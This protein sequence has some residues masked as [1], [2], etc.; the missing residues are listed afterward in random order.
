MDEGI[1]LAKAYVQIIPSARGISADLS[2]ELGGEA[3]KAG[4]QAGKKIASGIGSALKAGTAMIGAGLATA[5]TSVAALSKS[6]LSAY[7]DF[8]QL[9]GGV[10]TLF[11]ESADVVMQYADEAYKTSGLSAN[12]YMETVTSFSASLLQSLG[13]DTA[14]AAEYA[15]TAIVDMSD[16][17]NKMGTSMESIQN[18]YQG[19]AKQNFTMLDNLN[20]MGALA[21]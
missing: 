10:E 12:E 5:T 3:E 6:A 15:Q 13:G 18:A 16:N 1:N 4:S 11:K 20:T 2:A 14:A 19:F 7:A 9:T 21:A 17:A 8:E